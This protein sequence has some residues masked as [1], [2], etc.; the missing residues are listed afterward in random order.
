MRAYFAD[1]PKLRSEKYF[2]RNSL[3]IYKWRKRLPGQP[4]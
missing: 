3:A 1:K 2:W 4:G